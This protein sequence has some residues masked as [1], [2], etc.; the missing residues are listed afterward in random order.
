MLHSVCCLLHVA[1]MKCRVGNSRRSGGQSPG[2][3]VSKSRRRRGHRAYVAR[4]AVGKTVSRFPLPGACRAKFPAV[5]G[6]VRPSL[7]CGGRI[8]AA[9]SGRRDQR[10]RANA[11]IYR[12]PAEELPPAVVAVPAGAALFAAIRRMVV[13]DH[14]RRAADKGEGRCLQLRLRSH[15]AVVAV[16]ADA[17]EEDLPIRKRML[18]D[19]AIRQG[20]PA[21][22][23]RK[24]ALRAADAR[25][26][27]VRVLEC[28]PSTSHTSLRR[29][30]SPQAGHRSSTCR[31]RW[32]CA[33]RS[34]PS[35]PVPSPCFRGAIRS[36]IAY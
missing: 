24:D 2:A 12:G 36:L 5:C 8:L 13:A 6:M 28:T 10:C 20:R 27:Q 32:P 3:D 7:E 25:R 16:P 35:R 33:R 22:L 29:A 23:H 34:S 4:T 11:H 19:T 26:G 17:P 30:S 15:S 18:E 14:R 9:H 1:C 31:L 21:S